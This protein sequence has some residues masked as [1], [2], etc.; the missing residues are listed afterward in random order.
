MEKK[1]VDFITKNK[2]FNKGDR[3]VV[4]CSGGADSVALLVLLNKLKE[5]FKISVFAVHVNHGIRGEEAKRDE[6]YVCSLAKKLGIDYLVKYVDAP[7]Y[8][9]ENKKTLEQGAR[10]LRYE[11]LRQAKVE[12]GANK[13]AVAHNKGDQTESVLMHLCRGAGLSGVVGMTPV[14]NDIVRPLLEFEKDE[15]IDYLNERKIEFK[16]DYTNSDINYTR[17]F[18]R[19]E[20]IGGLKKVYPAV[21]ENIYK[22]S[23]K[24]QEVEEFILSNL[25]TDLTKKCGDS[26]VLL[27][28]ASGEQ[29]IIL[30]RL[31]FKALDEINARVD[32]EE[33]HIKEIGKLFG[34]QVGKRIVLPNSVDAVRVHDGILFERQYVEVFN[35]IPFRVDSEIV[36]KVGTIVVRR[37]VRA[38]LKSDDLYIDLDEIPN[39]AVWRHIEN[40][41]KFTKFS[42]GTK[43]LIKFLTDKKMDVSRRQKMLV[44]ASGDEILVVPGVEISNKVKITD[45]TKNI[46]SI[47]VV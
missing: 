14:S 46:L 22:F 16:E 1:L 41:D 34:M 25:P 8:A 7:L 17:N 35:P 18:I 38:K 10:E 39:D 47:S 42:G 36:S 9:S 29:P 45:K 23:K 20:I 37:A 31:I 11:V 5:K 30:S 19:H 21:C 33:K 12:V 2:L 44:L 32:I 40:G 28:E 24:M 4:A 27:K 3:V 13:I 15:L 6:N 26:V 43:T